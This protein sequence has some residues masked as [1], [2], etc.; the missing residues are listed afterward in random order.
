[1]KDWSENVSVFMDVMRFKK[2]IFRRSKNITTDTDNTNE[3]I[4]LEPVDLSEYEFTPNL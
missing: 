3:R 2:K 4:T 1:M